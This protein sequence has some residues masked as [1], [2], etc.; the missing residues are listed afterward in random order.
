MPLASLGPDPGLALLPDKAPWRAATAPVPEETMLAPIAPTG[1]RRANPSGDAEDADRARTTTGAVPEDEN[2]ARI[3]S[4]SSSSSSNR[5]PAGG[6]GNGSP[7]DARLCA[8]NGDA[9]PTRCPG[10]AA[11]PHP[12]VTEAAAEGEGEAGVCW[13]GDCRRERRG[14]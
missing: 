13:K 10:L 12:A 11:A 1:D 8:D 2:R 7:P 14:V 6:G 4:S 9:L 3:N 5:T